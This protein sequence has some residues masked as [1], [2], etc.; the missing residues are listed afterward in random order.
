MVSYSNPT[1]MAVSK[2]IFRHGCCEGDRELPC[3]PCDNAFHLCCREI[4]TGEVRGTCDFELESGLIEQNDDELD[5]LMYMNISGISNPIDIHGN[6]WPVSFSTVIYYDF[7]HL[8][9]PGKS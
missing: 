9:D 7:P 5:L 2:Q 8:S 1:S 3:S 6:M 4:P